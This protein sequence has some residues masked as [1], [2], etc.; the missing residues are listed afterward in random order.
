MTF[1]EILLPEFDQEMASTRKLLACL[2]DPVPAYKPHEKSMPMNRLAGHVAELPNWAL[3]AINRDSLDITPKPG[4]GFEALV[5][6]SRDELLRTFDRNVL[7]ARKAISELRDD[8]VGKTWT[9]IF[10]GKPVLQMPRGMVVRSVVINHLIHHRAQLGVYLRLN[11][12]AIPGMY[13]PSADEGRMF[14]ESA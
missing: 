7:E 4:Q 11:N 6:K 10:Q 14:A 2:P 1:A 3:N 13:G 5:A 9:L 12:V 8:Q